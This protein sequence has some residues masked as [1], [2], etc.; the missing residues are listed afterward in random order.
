MM[1][2]YV[3]IADDEYFIRQRLKKIIPWDELHL[4]FA[5]E[6]EN[7]RDILELIKTTPVDILFLD[8]QMAKMNGIETAQFIFQNYPHIKIV[9]LSGFHEFEYARSAMRFGAVAY[10]LKPVNKEDLYSVLT[11]CTKKICQEKQR[12]T[13][14]QNHYRHEKQTT[15]S[16]ALSGQLSFSDLLD[17][18]PFLSN[19]RYGLCIGIFINDETDC[20]VQWIMDILNSPDVECEYIRESNYSYTILLLARMKETIIQRCSIVEQQIHQAACFTFI[21]LSNIF[22]VQDDWR[23]PYKQALHLLNHRFFSQKSELL[24]EYQSSFSETSNITFSKIRQKLVSLINTRNKEE[25]KCYIHELFCEIRK[26]KNVNYMYLL[27]TELFLTYNIHYPKNF[28]NDGNM[29]DFISMTIDE[30][31]SLD[32]LESTLTF[33]GL[34][35]IESTESPP[36]DVV[37][38]NRITAYIKEHY[39]EPDL[40]VNRLAEHFQLNASYMGTL[41]KRI[42]NQSVIQYLI[43]V[44]MEAAVK[45][46]KEGNYRIT[47]IAEM[48]GYSDVFYFSK[49]FKKLYG[50][51]PKEYIQMQMGT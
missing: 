24:M 49:R 28:T 3:A 21:T 23:E 31:Y 46:M 47:D 39:S 35:C 44:R 20:P 19:M 27:I 10:L 33:Y 50:Y 37:F 43:Q 45:L 12:E 6:G 38:N 29:Q 25:L 42:N 15:L 7:G 32:N 11:D 8:I 14:L 1:N 9:I 16:L 5:G 13:Q 48:V 36:S 2:L 4:T 30:E 18:Y 17:A 51:S 34:K 41:F 22:L 26:R 40:S